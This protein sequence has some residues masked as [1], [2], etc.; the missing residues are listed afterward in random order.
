M[1][2]PNHVDQARFAKYGTNRAMKAT[3]MASGK[4]EELTP[5]RLPE[6]D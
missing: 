5:E 2:E 4:V 6:E 3:L 1:S